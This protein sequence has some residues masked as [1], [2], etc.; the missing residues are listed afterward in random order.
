MREFSTHLRQ[1]CR[2]AEDILAVPP[3][4]PALSAGHHLVERQVRGEPW[5]DDE[6]QQR[7]CGQGQEDRA[8]ELAGDAAGEVPP[9]PWVHVLSPACLPLRLEYRI[10]GL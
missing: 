10:A 5:E 4:V 7:R 1:S 8:C 6:P 3:L 9:E 2:M